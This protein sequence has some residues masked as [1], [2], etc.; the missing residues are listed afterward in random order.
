M[1]FAISEQYRRFVEFAQ[2]YVNQGN[3]DA[4][5]R[6]GGAAAAPLAGRTITIA[7]DNDHIKQWLRPGDQRNANDVARDLFKR[8][9]IDMFGGSMANVPQEVKDAMQLKNFNNGGHPLTARRIMFVKIEVDKIIAEAT[10]FNSTVLNAIMEGHANQLPQDMQNVLRT[11]MNDLRT[12]F[13]DNLVPA[14]AKITDVLNPS[15]VRTSLQALVNAANA[16]GRQLDAGA[17]RNEFAGKASRNLTIKVVGSHVLEKVRQ[18]PNAPANSLGEM[19]LAT[20]YDKR[21]PGFLGRIENCKTPDEIAA[22]LQEHEDEI[23]TFADLAARGL[24][25]Q[26]NAVPNAKA[27]LAAELGMDER[28]VD[29]HIPMGELREKVG[30]LTRDIMGGTAPGSREPGFNLQAAYDALVNQ[31]VQERKNA[32]NSVNALQQLPDSVKNRWQAD[33]VTNYRVPPLTPEQLLAAADVIDAR[34]IMGAFSKGLPTGVAVAALNN[35][36]ER[37]RDAIRQATNDQNFFEG[38]SVGDLQPVYSMILTLVEARN[39]AFAQA[40][41]NAGNEFFTSAITYCEANKGGMG[42]AAALV[43]ALTMRSTMVGRQ[44]LTNGDDYLVIMK[45]DVAAALVE[46]GVTDAKIIAEVKDAMLMRGQH[47]L[48]NATTLKELSDF[49]ANAKTEARTLAKTLEGIEKARKGALKTAT[50]TIAAFSGISKEYLT[51]KLNVSSVKE[52]LGHLYANLLAKA[53]NGENIDGTATLNKANDIVSKFALGKGAVL[54]AIDKAGFDPAECA[55]HKLSALRDPAWT[56]ADVVK[57]A[58]EL[59]GNETLKNAAQHLAVALKKEALQTLEDQQVRSVFLTFGQAFATTMKSQFGEYAEKWA[60]SPE[61]QKHLMKMVVDLLEQEHPDLAESLGSLVASGRFG[62]VKGMLEANHPGNQADG[63]L[64]NTTKALM[65]N[66]EDRFRETRTDTEDFSATRY[67]ASVRKGREVIAK[68]AGQLSLETIPVLAKLVHGLDWRPKKAAASEKIVETWVADMKNWRDILP[69]T[70]DSE[71]IERLF[72]RRMN[73]YVKAHL[74]MP[75]DFTDNIYSVFLYDL[76]R[77]SDY[78]VNGKKAEG[79][80]RAERLVLFTTTFKDPEK[81]KVVSMALNQQLWADFT[82]VANKEQLYPTGPGMPYVAF[83]TLL[84]IDK[85]VVRDITANNQLPSPTLGTGKMV[86][87]IEVSPDES[88]VTVHSTSYYPINGAVE[89]GP[90]SKIGKCTVTQDFVF[91]FTGPEPAI[92]DYKVG[93]AIE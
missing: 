11:V 44:S 24:A 55:A 74:A 15:L 23:N 85:V 79:E 93:Q 73:D 40:V 2:T 48:A 70:S 21:H 6:D 25:A 32:Y 13:G 38:K 10:A 43:K 65:E 18:Q 39:P 82:T 37:I 1:A 91:D 89:M 49:L 77:S 75:N 76:E 34:K 12:R 7:N 20:Q 27:R 90:Q 71:G 51:H 19:T 92:R 14:D 29:I 22:A 16:D 54:Q 84:G 72:T 64:Y 88:A 60:N 69:G 9:I 67:A 66:F 53:K 87:A 68:Y 80:T 47:V 81:F 17:I 30:D 58:K 52:S 59:A 3:E 31:F 26:I 46:S 41:R 4:I 42:G 83:D 62:T 5:A 63:E 57:V 8:T 61:T 50:T 35:V 36:N 78:F 45:D 86:F 33:Y 56:D 28:F